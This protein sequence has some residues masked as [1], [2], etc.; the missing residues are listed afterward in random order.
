MERLSGL[1]RCHLQAQGGLRNFFGWQLPAW[2]TDA[3]S[4]LA[5]LRSSAGI[6]DVS[7]LTKLDLRGTADE[8]PAPARLWKLTST[9]R[10]VTSPQPIA[11][12]P[13]S[14]ITDLTSLYSAI[15]LAG[16]KSRQVLE[17]LTTLNV[18]EAAMPEGA[19][20]QTRL[21]HVNAV[22]L[23]G[24]GFFLL[25]T[26]DVAEHVWEALLHAGASPFGLI[27]Q[28]QWLGAAHAGA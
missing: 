12:T 17:K 10:L 18:N 9:R 25:T 3:F 11:F 8:F 13:S 15:L 1:H 27:A 5:Q 7:Y 24:Q 23:R 16:P 28:Q 19:A 4:E 22:I 20:R 26:R 6:S 14:S 2:Y 21:A